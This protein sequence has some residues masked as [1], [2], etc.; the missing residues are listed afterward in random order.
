[1]LRAISLIITLLS[2]QLAS[3]TTFYMSPAGDDT[4]PGTSADHPWKSCGKVNQTKFAPGDIVLFQRG[5]TWRE[6]L[7]PASDGAT[8]SPITF[9]A[10]G[11]GDKP[12]FCGSDLLDN[13]K[14]SPTADGKYATPV[15]A[16]ADTALC[17]HSFIPSTWA[18]G[19]PTLTT[20][21]DPRS[22]MKQYT[23]CL[24][25]NVIFSNRKNHLVFRNLVV[26]ETAGQLSE[27]VVQGYGI[28]IEGSTDV[29]LEN[30]EA[31]RCGRHHIA[32]INTT[33]F[34]GRHL[35]AAYVVPNMPGGNTAYVSYAD[36]GAPVAKCTS[37]WDDIA[38]AHL[39]DGK[40]GQSLTFVS[41]GDHQGPITIENSVANT[42]IS[43]M[44]A[45]A[46]VKKVTLRETASIENFGAGLMVDSCTLLDGS[47]IDQWST[48]G[49]IQNCVANLTT[50]TGGGATG[51]TSAIV[52]RDKAKDNTI[53]FNTL[54]TGRFSC[55]TFAGENS[56]TKWYGNIF[57]ADGATVIKP[58]SPLAAAD[59]VMADFNF[60]SPNAAFAGKSLP[61]WQAMG[62]DSH[63]PAGD[64]MCE[65][66]AAGKF[67]LKAGSPCISDAKL[68]SDQIA[69]TDFNG[70]KRPAQNP[71]VG[72]VEA[73]HP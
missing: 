16:Q 49:T 64:P 14:F 2:S 44:S 27:G 42:K 37:E 22:D 18:D 4:S 10:Y 26:D 21:T 30:C 31:Y 12:R 41:H 20:A 43:F 19:K 23:A 40:G 13:S 38:A 56:A 29:L 67:G 53:R 5:A 66:P 48:G 7:I 33:G 9:D 36:A 3:A 55:L 71:S 25:G 15:A 6:S 72:A 73:N 51:Y 54:I 32:A 58:P 17:D 45:P 68:G 60:Y 11:D 52:L 24:R 61:D 62:F 65:D 46:I 1:M 8:D 39:D 69:V 47:A 35:L 50:P 59:V 70:A 63:S 34:V 57:C 28:R